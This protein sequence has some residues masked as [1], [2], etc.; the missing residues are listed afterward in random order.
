MVL[1]AICIHDATVLNTVLALRE[2]GNQFLSN[3]LLNPES[4]YREIL[5]LNPAKQLYKAH[6][7]QINTYEICDHSNTAH[8]NIYTLLTAEHDG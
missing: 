6:L 1:S 3:Q 8:Y 7:G 5:G 2:P 4:N